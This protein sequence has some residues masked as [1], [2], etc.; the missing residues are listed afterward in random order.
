MA[1]RRTAPNAFQLDA[2]PAGF[3]IDAYRD[4][5][6]YPF[7]PGDRVTTD[8]LM[9]EVKDVRNGR[10]TIIGVEFDRPL[11]DRSLYFVTRTRRGFQPIAMPPIGGELHLEP[12]TDPIAADDSQAIGHFVEEGPEVTEKRSVDAGFDGK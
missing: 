10:P 4:P 3:D 5:R 7:R 11:E 2:M 12:A 1:L 8:G 9:L 6:R